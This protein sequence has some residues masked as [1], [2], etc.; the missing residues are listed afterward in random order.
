MNIILN[1]TTS[2]MNDEQDEFPKLSNNF[3][4]FELERDIET[5]P[6]IEVLRRT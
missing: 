3:C 2:T 4:D 1:E 5:K 6:L